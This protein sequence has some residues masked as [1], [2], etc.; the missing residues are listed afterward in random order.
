MTEYNRT[1]YAPAYGSSFEYPFT[2]RF[3]KGSVELF[4]KLFTSPLGV[5]LHLAEA[6]VTL[7]WIL[8][9][10][11]WVAICFLVALLAAGVRAALRGVVAAMHW[12]EAL[13]EEIA[14][15]DN[16]RSVDRWMD[17]LLPYFLAAIALWFFVELTEAGMRHAYAILHGG[18]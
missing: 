7:L 18:Y 6:A 2:T 10:W 13:C 3:Y 1:R 5:L 4:I 17:K 9:V 12:F 16:V 15:D 14:N 11:S 8:C